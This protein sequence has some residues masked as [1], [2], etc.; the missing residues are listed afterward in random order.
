MAGL[1]DVAVLPKSVHT[2][3]E[4]LDLLLTIP[5]HALVL[6]EGEPT[7]LHAS[8]LLAARRENIRN[9]EDVRGRRLGRV[10]EPKVLQKAF[11]A[12]KAD[13]VLGPLFNESGADYLLGDIEENTATVLTRNEQF[14]YELSQAACV[15]D[16]P[17]GHVRDGQRSDSGNNCAVPGCTGKWT[18]Y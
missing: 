12:G 7:V 8:D 10:P 5:S 18:C 1:I 3:D 9:I 2:V 6:A 15:C 16:A 13:D 14:E 4:A 17:Q 11:L